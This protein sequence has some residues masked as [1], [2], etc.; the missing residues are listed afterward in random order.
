MKGAY[1]KT[2][3]IA[4]EMRPK[5]AQSAKQMNSTEKTDKKGKIITDHL[6]HN[7]KNLQLLLE[8]PDFGIGESPEARAVVE[9]FEFTLR[10]LKEQSEE[11]KILKMQIT[12]KTM[13]R[14][15]HGRITKPETTAG[16]VEG[17]KTASE[18]GKED[19]S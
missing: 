5:A 15:R 13:E 1:T 8:V 4:E 3:P 7:L 16:R 10:T 14:R 18:H 17:D 9:M 11:I 6:G 2:R 19:L 12:G